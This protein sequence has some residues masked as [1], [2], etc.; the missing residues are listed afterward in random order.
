MTLDPD[1]MSDE[2]LAKRANR[3]GPE[4]TA[5]TSTDL[6]PP[7]PKAELVQKVFNQKSTLTAGVGT[8]TK[9]SFLGTKRGGANNAAERGRGRGGRG[10]GRGRG[11]RFLN[12]EQIIST[13]FAV[14]DENIDWSSMHVVGTCTNI[15]KKYFRLTTVS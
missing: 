13:A 2:K 3:F 8:D 11:K 10:F 6:P 15:P 1:M 9:P 14:D 12:I 4:L 5:P 7:E